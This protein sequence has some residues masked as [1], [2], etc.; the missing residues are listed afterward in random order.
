MTTALYPDDKIHRLN[1]LHAWWPGGLI[2]GGLVGVLATA[3]HWSWQAAL[4]LMIVPA[5]VFGYLA[6]NTRFPA[7]ERVQAGV[8]FADMFRETLR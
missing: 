7:T 5:L 2:A 3:S 6:C 1:V 4:G 8:S